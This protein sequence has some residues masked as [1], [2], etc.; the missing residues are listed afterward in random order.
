[1]GWKKVEA[2]QENNMGT[3]FGLLSFV[4]FIVTIVGLIKPAWLK[5]A[6]RGKVLLWYG[7][8]FL[9]LFV[10]GVSITSSENPAPTQDASANQPAPSAQ[11]PTPVASSTSTPTPV[12]QAAASA[13]AKTAPTPAP[14]P[15]PVQTPTPQPT[16]AP[17][18][19]TVLNI[20]G[21]GSKSTQTFTVG[22]SWQMQWSY[23]C[24]VFGYQGNFQVSISTADG[25]FTPNQ[26]VNQLGASGSDTEYYHSGGTYY[27]EVNSECSWHITVIG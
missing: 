11:A 22:D 4:A 2:K 9:L 25:G 10:I 3:F 14:T 21:S 6:T 7:G 24:S 1:M 20:S 26:G 5:L 23:D 13:P 19:Q 27:L 15:A 17:Q 18:P 12:Q 8:G 16:P